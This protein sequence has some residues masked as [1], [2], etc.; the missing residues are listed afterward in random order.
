MARKKAKSRPNLP[1]EVLD[2]ARREASGE[3]RYQPSTPQADAKS[4]S[5]K[6]QA[7]QA[8]Q[9][10]V[11]DLAKEYAYVISDLRNM[12]LLA[13]ALF[14]ALIVIALIL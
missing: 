4:K 11:E 1:Q 2:R 9:T 3:P 10:T 7:S 8:T 5:A 14:A 13:A 6:A 12:G